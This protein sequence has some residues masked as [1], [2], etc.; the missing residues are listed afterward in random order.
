M[1]LFPS[2]FGPTGLF[3]GFF[4]NPANL[5]VALGFAVPLIL[6]YLIRPKPVNVAVPSLMFILNDMGKSNV[7]RFFRSILR[8]LLF[9]IQLLAIVLLALAMAKP[10]MNVSQESLVKQSI[11]VI[12]ASASSRAFDDGRFDQIRSSATESLSN[13]NIVIVARASPYVLEENGNPHLSA[14]KAKSLIKDLQPSDMQGDLPS[15]LDLAG[16]YVGPDSKVTVVSDFILSSLESPDL[17]KAKVKVLRSKGALVETKTISSQGN[18]VGIID[19]ALNSQNATLD[20]KIQNFNPKPSEIG[21]EYNGKAITLPKNLL[22]P[23][24]KPGSLMSVSI[25]LAH[26]KS[27]I[28]L[29]PKDDFDTDNHYY[30]SIPDRDSINVLLISNDPNVQGSKL[31]PA[32]NAAGDQFTKVNVQY[33]V[34]PKIPDLDHQVYIIKDANPEFILP[35]V[36]KELRDKVNDGAV[37]VV[38]GQSG[39]FGIDT[40]DLLPVRPKADA[41]PL[42]GKQELVV[43][44]SLGLMRGLSDIGQVDGSQLL[45][46]NKTEDAVVHAYVM[47]NDGPEPVIAHK[48]IGKGV[49]IYYGIKDQKAID[50]DPQSYAIIWGR[51]IDYSIPDTRL[52]NVAT[53]SVITAPTKTIITPLGKQPSPA[54]AARAGI[55]LAGQNAIAANLYPLHTAGG[56]SVVSADSNIQYESAI[57][58]SV[59]ITADEVS[60]GQGRPEDVKVPKDLSLYIIMAGMSV[61]LFEFLFI[62][63]RGDL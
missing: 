17:I 63:Y 21:L 48:R 9:L 6:L 59:N 11:I 54:I 10:F 12:D 25:P 35:G 7:H 46:V 43:N 3:S 50:L 30:V 61:M 56:P 33:A 34:P 4:L 62:K 57:S 24:G 28:L 55:Y 19:A 26:G 58:N 51:I 15:A 40:L 60:S 14:S 52:L 31:V 29:T 2:I 13:D 23:A 27:E 47:T 37:L 1:V 16:Q 38:Y 53:G 45:R 49:V 22:E 18:N 44:S 39:L 5:L 42:G 8:D 20:I 36:I 41:Q 32:L